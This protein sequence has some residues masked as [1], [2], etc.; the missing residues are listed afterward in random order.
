M[1]AYPQVRIRPR[2]RSLRTPTAQDYEDPPGLATATS[3]HD[4]T[5]PSHAHSAAGGHGPTQGQW[6][7]RWTHTQL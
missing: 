2:P 1:R 7:Q 5:T 3:P 4:P 6:W